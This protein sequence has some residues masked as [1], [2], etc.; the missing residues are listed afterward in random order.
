LLVIEH[1]GPGDG[2]HGANS[3]VKAWGSRAAERRL[4]KLG[5]QFKD[6]GAERVD[7]LN[8]GNSR[9]SGKSTRLRPIAA[10]RCRERNEFG[11]V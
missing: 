3:A 2:G 4:T 5:E 11:M 6:E 7:A 8:I 10:S 1:M 9:Q